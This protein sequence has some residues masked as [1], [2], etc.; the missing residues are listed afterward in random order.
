MREQPGS[1]LPDARDADTFRVLLDQPARAVTPGQALVCYQ[2][3]RVVG[4]GVIADAF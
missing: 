4:G 3:D 2:E 1:L